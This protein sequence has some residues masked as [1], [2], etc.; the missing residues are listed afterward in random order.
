MRYIVLTIL[1]LINIPN[2]LAQREGV[3]QLRSSFSLNDKLTDLKGEPLLAKNE[4]ST[5]GSAFFSNEWSR[6]S[7]T[8]VSGKKYS[9]IL[10]KINLQTDDVH[11]LLEETKAERVAGKGIVK[12][13][14]FKLSDQQD[15]IRFRSHFPSVEKNDLLTFYQVLVDGEVILLK[16]IKRIFIEEKAFNSATITHRFDTDNSYF[17]CL[18]KKMIKLKRNRTNILELLTD[19]RSNLEN[20]LSKNNISFKSDQ[21]LK[22]L[23]EYY[24]SLK[25]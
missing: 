12:Q 3:T 17:I 7:L 16:R 24:N 19:Q 22:K 23:F 20:Y 4:V 2:C 15:S 14:D 11:Y 18:N 6:G 13:V 21:D 5:D 9:S 8:L 10:L 25:H 1:T